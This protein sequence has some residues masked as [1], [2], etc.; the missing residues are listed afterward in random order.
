MKK[1]ICL[2]IAVIAGI[3]ILGGALAATLYGTVWFTTG[4]EAPCVE[5]ELYDDTNCEDYMDMVVTDS[6]GRYEFTDLNDDRWYYVYLRFKAVAC[7]N[8][9]GWS[10][11]CPPTQFCDSAYMQPDTQFTYHDFYLGLD[12]CSSVG[13]E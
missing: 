2:A 4:E 10:G 3:W 9:G 12:D 13:C 6:C 5:V 7:A 1:L 8:G 11:I